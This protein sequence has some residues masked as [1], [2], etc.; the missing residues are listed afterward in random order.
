[1]EH[2]RYRCKKCNGCGLVKVTSITCEVCHGIKCMRC[3]ASGLQRMPWITCD[4]CDGAG[5]IDEKEANLL[6]KLGR[7]DKYMNPVINDCNIDMSTN[8]KNKQN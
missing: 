6:R 8:E 4:N 3:G 1:M 2:K 7:F 5:D